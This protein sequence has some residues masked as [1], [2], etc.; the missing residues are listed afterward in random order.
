MITYGSY[1]KKEVSIETS[2]HQI[3]IFDTGIAFL[4]GLMVIPAMFV[5]NPDPNLAQSGPSLMF[6]ALPKVFASM[7]GGQII[8]TVFFLLVLL[9]ALTSSI[10]LMETVVSVI[11]D[12]LKWNRK[13]VCLIVFIVSVAIGLPSAF[14]FS[15]WSEFQML[16]MDILTLFDYITNNVLMPIIAMLTAIFVGY[17][18]KPEAIVEEVELSG[19]FKLKSL[20]TAM[21]KFV[22][23]IFLLIIFVFGFFGGLA[24]AD[25]LKDVPWV[26]WLKL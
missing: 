1:M 9:A 12:K 13:A 24:N 26:Q 4:A 7:F 23:P 16:G 17:V 25:F 15:I 22:A 2:V 3:E 18:I 10:S 20:F 5:G 11:Q 8:G 19:K 14:G 6:A 21:I